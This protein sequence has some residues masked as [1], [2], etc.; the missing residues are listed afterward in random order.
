MKQIQYFLI[1]LLCIPLFAQTVTDIDGNVYQTVIIGNQEW[2]AENLKVS[3]YQNGDAIP[4]GHSNTDWSN[5]S[6]GAYAVYNDDTT[7]FNT[8]GYLY[9]WYVVNDTQNIAPA[10]WHVPT[11]DEY[12]ELEMALGMS[13]SEA[14]GT[15][16]RGTNEGSQLAGNDTLWNSGGLENNSEFGASGF[17]ALPSGYR[18]LN[19]SYFNLGS[20]GYFW[21]STT[22]SGT[23][24]WKRRLSY[25]SPAVY[26]YHYNRKS[27]LPI[28]CIKDS[29]ATNNGQT[30]VP[31]DNFE[32]YL[33]ANGM[34]NGIANDDSVTTANI[35]MLINLDIAS[36]GIADLTGI[37]DFVALEN[38][39]CE[40]NNLTSLDLNANILLEYLRCNNNSIATLNINNNVQLTGLF[41]DHNQLTVLDVGNNSVL[42]HLFPS[43]NDLTELDVSAN[44]LIEKINFGFNALTSFDVTNNPALWYLGCRENELT[45]LDLRNGNNTITAFSSTG[46]SDLFCID[47]DDVAWADTTLIII[48]PW[49]SFN[50]DCA[51]GGGEQT[52]V[53]DDNFEAYLEAN[54]MGNGIANDDSVTTANINTVGTLNVENQSIANMMGLEDFTAISY[55]RCN[56]NNLAELDISENLNL[57][58]LYCSDNE[59]TSLD[60]SNNALLTILFPSYNNLTELDVSANPLMEK[61]NCGRNNITSLDVTSNPALWYFGCIENNLTSLDLRNGNNTILTAFNST[62]N[63]DL[64]CIDVDNVA[65]ADTALAY[66]DSWTSFSIDCSADG[67]GQTYVPDDNFEAYLEANGMG[68][69]IA[70]DDSV[71]TA[72]IETIVNLN[73]MSSGIADMTGLEDFTALSVF[74]CSYNDLTGLDVSANTALT[75]LYCHSNELPSLD[76]STNTALTKLICNTNQLTSLDVTANTALSWLSCASNQLTSLNVAANTALTYLGCRNNQLSSLDLSAN[77]TLTYL[78]CFANQL[79]SLDLSANTILS[80]LGCDNNQLTNLDLSTNTALT[81]L[82]CYS[83]DLTSLDVT[84]NTVLI[85]LRCHNNQLSSLNVRNGNNTSITTFNAT[86]NPNLTCI[87]VDNVAWADSAW[88]GIDSWT[89]FS[90]DCSSMP[91]S[92]EPITVTEFKLHDAY[93]NP[94][95]PRTS[96]RYD[97]PKAS[98]VSISIY[99]LMGRKVRNLVTGQVSAGSHITQWDASNDMGSQVSAGVYIYTISADDF[100]EVKKMILLK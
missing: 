7:N 88:T 23:N 77:T 95:N 22:G 34:G 91:V 5:L 39:S 3:H 42:T 65:W 10:G 16:W 20:H 89:S 75:E 70:N 83:N 37:E 19:G 28:R 30:Y 36:M 25:F 27:G 2:M 38:L 6:T 86:V 24:S 81:Q 87:D 33:E 99:D 92:E 4:T 43:N 8:Y 79:T 45:E 76:V 93:P 90:T 80:Y 74:R 21:S 61:I 85:E 40:W 94:F 18:D 59:L 35:E 58:I 51:T 54:G 29:S 97:L 50:T 55:L 11:D 44:L 64:T 41:C 84:A 17:I 53:P 49:T 52:Y 98:K 60:V 12:K 68:N 26:R 71:T 46:N 73:V 1:A 72:N 100:R 78:H 69:G 66:I 15:S 14:D 47:V 48:D 62:N 96:I 63:P 9:N 57:S 13:Q 31:D 56:D 32:A 67:G 82:N